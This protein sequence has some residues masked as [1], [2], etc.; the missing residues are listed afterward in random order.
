MAPKK[1]EQLYKL[2]GVPRNAKLTPSKKVAGALSPLVHGRAKG[3]GRG[4]RKGIVSQVALIPVDS[5]D[6]KRSL[7][8]Y[9]GVLATKTL[10]VVAVVSAVLAAIALLVSAV[11]AGVKA[12]LADVADAV[13]AGSEYLVLGASVAVAIA[14]AALGLKVARALARRRKRALERTE[15]HRAASASSGEYIQEPR[16]AQPNFGAQRR[17]ARGGASRSASTA[18]ANWYPDPHHKNHLRYWDGAAWT[19]HVSPIQATAM[20]PAGWYLDPANSAQLRYWSG[21]GWT[22]HFAP[23]RNPVPSTTLRNVTG[24][25]PS[26]DERR[27]RMST[28][29]WQAHVRAWMATGTVEQEL[30][31]RL[32]NAQIVDADGLTLEAQRRLEQLTAE[33]GAQRIRLMLDANP[34]M[35]RDLDLAGFMTQLLINLDP[36][37]WTT[38]LSLDRANEMRSN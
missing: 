28:A 33:Q 7:L 1:R 14:V 20:S 4:R 19:H 35:V 34:G 10:F 26:S 2:G 36:A 31:R 8:G 12:G 21:S 9:L 38:P 27:T 17:Q 11:V 18:P 23:R 6:T 13:S 29:E 15:A 25:P 30:W 16:V 3:K 5:T 22:A 32:T 37:H 24:L